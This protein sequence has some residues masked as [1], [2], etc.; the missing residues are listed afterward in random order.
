MEVEYSGN[1][2]TV[3]Q[4]K[5]LRQ[6][7][8]RF[9]L[10]GRLHAYL[11]SHTLRDDGAQGLEQAYAEIAFAEELRPSIDWYRGLAT[12]MAAE[13]RVQNG[14]P[15]A[16]L[17]AYDRSVAHF[18]ASIGGEADFKGSA[19]HYICL[20]LAGAARVHVDAGA[21]QEAVI[22]IEEGVTSNPMSLSA[23][24]GLGN[25]P[26]QNAR[27]V[28]NTLRQSGQQEHAESLRLALS[29]SGLVLGG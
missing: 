28:Y 17:A 13:R 6:G 15:R 22:A 14:D 24:D 25:T 2:P 12:L 7:L 11:R 16:A 26:S 1:S 10:A 4:A 20:A 29:E 5:I 8:G 21:W 18:R 3:L 27:H 23:P 9:P 19:T